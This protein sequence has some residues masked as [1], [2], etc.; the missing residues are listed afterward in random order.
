M[1]ARQPLQYIPGV[2]KDDTEYFVQGHATDSNWVRFKGM[3]VET[4]PGFLRK[5]EEILIGSP[6]GQFSWNSNGGVTYQAIGTTR[7]LY[8]EI[9]GSIFDITPIDDEGEDIDVAIVNGEVTATVTHAQHGRREGDIVYL[10]GAS[11]GGGSGTLSLNAF[12]TSQGSRIIAVNFPSHGFSTGE[13]VTISSATVFN[14]VDVNGVYSIWVAGPDTFMISTEDAATATSSGGGTANW[15]ST[16]SYEVKDV[17]DIN[18][19][20][21]ELQSPASST[22]TVQVNYK[23]EMDQEFFGADLGF[24][25]GPFGLGFE[26]RIQ[27]ESRP[28]TWTFANFGEFLLANPLGR[29]IYEWDLLPSKRAVPVQNAPAQVDSIAVSGELIV[30]AFGCTDVNGV[31]NPK[32][33]RWTDVRDN[34]SW[35]IAINRLAGGY[36]LPEGAAIRRGLATDAGVVILTDRAFYTATFTGAIDEIYRFDLVATQCGLI[37]SRAVAEKDGNLWWIGNDDFYTFSN[38]FV[39]KIPSGIRDFVFDNMNFRNAGLSFVT[40]DSANTGVMFCYPAGEETNRYARLDLSA[41]SAENLSGWSVGESPFGSMVDFS[42]LEYPNAVTH[43]GRL[44]EIGLSNDADGVPIHKFIKF[45]PVEVPSEQGE[46]FRTLFVTRAIFDAVN[47]GPVEM[48]FYTRR[49]PRGNLTVRGPFVLSNVDFKG[50]RVK[51][52]QVGMKIQ[53]TASG[54]KWRLGRVRVDVSEGPRR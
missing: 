20:T 39:E 4:M 44:V 54:S 24:G 11:V 15:S 29:T 51:A 12:T 35:A 37:G 45:S 32:L 46:G 30:F 3:S 18:S 38:G 1:T 21:V 53:S 16:R 33:V 5:N 19:Y 47:E 6:R 7:K 25:V 48:T 9:E 13:F 22:G 43:E 42:P 14:G 26:P 2:V 10:D 23:Y 40:L 49:Y 52:R 31:Y 41:Y 28:R 8:A 34:T 17:I 36:I 27:S 50:L